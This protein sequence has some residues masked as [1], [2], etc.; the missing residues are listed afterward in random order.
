MKAIRVHEF[1]GPQ[2][3][4]LEDVPDP[5][6]GPGQVLVRVH[7]AGV[8]PVDTYMRS[9]AEPTRKKRCAWNHRYGDYRRRSHSHKEQ[10]FGFR[11][12]PRIARCSNLQMPKPPASCLF[13]EQAAVWGLLRCS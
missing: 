10:V 5:K 12:A 7:A 13:T 4:K 1:G 11:T 6:V 8:N 9:G 2:V 3:M